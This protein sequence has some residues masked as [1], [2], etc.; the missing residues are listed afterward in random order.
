MVVLR[1]NELGVE[2]DNWIAASNRRAT[3]SLV[4]FQTPTVV[5]QCLQFVQNRQYKHRSFYSYLR[6]CSHY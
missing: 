2:M 3:V 4:D 5:A 1:D 6:E